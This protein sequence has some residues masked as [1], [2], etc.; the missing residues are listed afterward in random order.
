MSWLDA[1]KN[2]PRNLRWVE[3]PFTALPKRT[4]YDNLFAI[5]MHHLAKEE[6]VWLDVRNDTKRIMVFTSPL[7][8]YSLVTWLE[9]NLH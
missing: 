9:W 2:T 4:S 5:Q 7:H 1:A 6:I 8:H 3:L